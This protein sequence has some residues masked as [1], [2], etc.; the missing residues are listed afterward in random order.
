MMM[1]KSLLAIFAAFLVIAT[2]SGVA[3]AIPWVG[4]GTFGGTSYNNVTEFDWDF[5]PPFDVLNQTLSLTDIPLTALLDIDGNPVSGNI[6]ELKLDAYYVQ[7]GLADDIFRITYNSVTIASGTFSELDS[8][9]DFDSNNYD[10][11]GSVT[12]FDSL[13][14]SPG[15]GGFDLRGSNTLN[16]ENF[17]GSSTFTE[18]APVPEPATMTLAGLGLACLFRAVRRKPRN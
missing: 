8:F 2:Q 15:I 9:L 7:N 17:D 10:F 4:T 18:S 5:G 16:D 13:Y 3:N 6:P 11:V 12:S 14:F 1:R